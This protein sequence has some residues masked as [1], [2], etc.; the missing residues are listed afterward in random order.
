MADQEDVGRHRR[1]GIGNTCCVRGLP[2]EV[3]QFRTFDTDLELGRDDFDGGSGFIGSGVFRN[4]PQNIRDFAGGNGG[5]LDVEFL[6]F[7]RGEI[8]DG[9][10]KNLG[11]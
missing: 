8:A 3:T 2:L 9:E 6:R 4:G 10:F 11:T 1:A 5:Q 7:A